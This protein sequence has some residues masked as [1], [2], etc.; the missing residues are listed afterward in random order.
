[1]EKDNNI[2]D[3]AERRDKKFLDQI[4]NDSGKIADMIIEE[5]FADG[6]HDVD[7]AAELLCNIG[8]VDD[9]AEI[10]AT[11]LSMDVERIARKGYKEDAEA[12]R[13]RIKERLDP[14]YEKAVKKQKKKKANTEEVYSD[15]EALYDSILQEEKDRIKTFVKDLIDDKVDFS[16]MT[17]REAYAVMKDAAKYAFYMGDTVM[18]ELALNDEKAS[19][20]ITFKEGLPIVDES[21]IALSHIMNLFTSFDV[22][23]N[24]KKRTITM[25]FEFY[26]ISVLGK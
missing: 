9:T 5:C 25:T 23:H 7:R 11:L 24:T 2:I 22:R 26:E 12:L 6:Q 4:A 20:K 21:R 13:E 14:M 15:P 16:K 17:N 18:D 8:E 19:I 1:M 3:F 10:R